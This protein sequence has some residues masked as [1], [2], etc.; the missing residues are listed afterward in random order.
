MKT[1]HMSQ[2]CCGHTIPRRAARFRSGYH[3]IQRSPPQRLCL[4]K[5]C[6]ANMEA[7]MAR[8]MVANMTM[9]GIAQA[10]KE[11]FPTSGT[12]GLGHLLLR[13]PKAFE[14]PGQHHKLC[15]HMM[16]Q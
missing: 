12:L 6:T 14:H 3:Q 1:A 8:N 10:D 16:A 5:I 11:G 4:S 15:D 7:A 2:T 13:K 9:L